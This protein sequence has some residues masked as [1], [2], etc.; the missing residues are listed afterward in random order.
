MGSTEGDIHDSRSKRRRFQAPITNYFTSA[1]LQHSGDDIAGCSSYHNYAAPTFSSIPPLPH[2][3]QASLLTVGMRIRKSVP[4]GYKTTGKSKRYPSSS[5]V[6]LADTS[7]S[8]YACNPDVLGTSG[9]AYTELAP[10]CGIL[11]TG[12][13]AVQTFPEPNVAPKIE[14]FA[15][16][17]WHL[18]PSWSQD[19]TDFGDVI[20]ATPNPHKRMFESE[21][22]SV[23]ENIEPPT[24]SF[25][26][27]TLTD[28]NFN[29]VDSF[30][31]LPSSSSALH[32]PPLPSRCAEFPKLGQ[33]SR[34]FRSAL[35]QSRHHYYK[36]RVRGQEN[37][38]PTAII[39]HIDTPFNDFEEAVFLRRRE[40]V[41]EECGPGAE[42][43]MGE[44]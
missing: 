1:G 15:D 42:V 35:S 37:R 36:N 43:N 25:P 16:D 31:N 11:K 21:P 4:E 19:S 2:K 7:S 3:I 14:P 38:D 20:A 34:P 39:D 23:L 17:Q 5:S 40:E 32:P 44:A 13:F 27:N 18:E 6:N 24:A 30:Q 12:N 10:Y 22:E 8:E 28:R 33:R 29:S 9:N 41:D 26:L